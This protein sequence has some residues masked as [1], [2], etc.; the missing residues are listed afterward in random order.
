VIQL[1][2]APPRRPHLTGVLQ[3]KTKVFADLTSVNMKKY[4][5]KKKV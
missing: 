5:L 4:H 3:Y 2:F 1:F